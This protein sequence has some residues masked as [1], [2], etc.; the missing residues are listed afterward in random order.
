MIEC[1]FTVDYEIYGN[2]EGSL[3]ELVLE[4]AE[5]LKI[6]FRKHNARFVVFVEAAELEIIGSERADQAIG[7]VERQ[8]RE[9]HGQGFEVGLHLHPQWYNARRKDARRQLDYGEYNLCVLLPDRINQ[10]IDRSIAYLRKVLGASH[11]IPL[12]FRAGNWLMQPTAAAAESLAG[13]GIRIDSS[14]FK[15]G[16]QHQHGLDYRRSRR[17]GYYWPFSGDVNIPDPKGI[18]LEMPTYTKMVPAWRMLSSKRVGLRQK[19]A[20]G[21]LKRPGRLSRIRDY[22][23]PCQPMKLDFCRLTAKELA[24]MI[25]EEIGKDRKDPGRFRPIVAIGHTKD[26]VDLET[27]ESFL[28]YLRGKGIP[29]STFRNVHDRIARRNELS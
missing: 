3:R 16:L 1:I 19:S 15:G 12:S 2:G 5:K 23:R 28:S 26:L 7:L 18:L 14:V 29:V 22:L 21:H 11:Y 4:P 20:K 17:N 9:F 27:V 10:I 24:R 13:H 8:I 25:D 6:I